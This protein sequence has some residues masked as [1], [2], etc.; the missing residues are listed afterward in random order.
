MN[1]VSYRAVRE[2]R[3]RLF[4]KLQR[5]S[6]QF[7][8][9]KRTG[10]LMSRIVND[11]A[12]INNA[13]SF[14]LRDLIHEF[15]RLLIYITIVFSIGGKMALITL[16]LLPLIIAPAVKIGKKL[17]KI[18]T[19]TQEKIADITSLLSETISGVRIV[20]AFSMEDYE[21]GRFKEQNRQFFNFLLKAAKRSLLSTPLSEIAGAMSATLILYLWGREVVQGNISFGAFGLV[22]GS[23]MSLMQ[24][25][26]KLTEVHFITQEGL[27][28]SNRIYQVLEEESTIKE[29][30]SAIAL[31]IEEVKGRIQRKAG[32]VE[33]GAPRVMIH[34]ENL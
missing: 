23:L 10:E 31:L 25:L 19:R 21:I 1:T 5:L 4:T 15:L 18:S 34:L 33:G 30:P 13:I 8:S 22:M 12:R 28:A 11:V 9:Q 2:V 3:N 29:A 6:L 32:V 16:L 26:K 7:Y 27:A 14:A 20:K 24:P 17:K